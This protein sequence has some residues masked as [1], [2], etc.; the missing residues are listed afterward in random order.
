MQP[1]LPTSNRRGIS[2][3]DCLFSVRI[4]RTYSVVRQQILPVTVSSV[5]PGVTVTAHVSALR[6]YVAAGTVILPST[7]S[8]APVSEL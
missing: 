4:F 1:L 7:V 8:N 2:R 5:V 3:A 6:E